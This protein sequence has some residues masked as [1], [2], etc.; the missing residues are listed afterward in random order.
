MKTIRTFHR[1][2]RT[3]RHFVV[4]NIM[5]LD[6]VCVVHRKWFSNLRTLVLKANY[7]EYRLTSHFYGFSQE[8]VARGGPIDANRYWYEFL[9]PF[10]KIKVAGIMEGPDGDLTLTETIT[11]TFP[12]LIAPF[13]WLL[14]PLFEKQKRDIL[15]AD[16]RLLERV[17]EL[18]RTGLKRFPEKA[19]KPR[20]VVFGGNGFFGRLLVQDLLEYTGANITIASRHLG[21]ASFHPYA[22]RVQF[23]VSDIN[24]DDSVRSKIEGADIAVCCAGPYQKLTLNLLQACLEKNVHYIDLSDDRNFVGRVHAAVAQQSGNRPLP[25]ICSGWSAVPALS[26]LL[27][28]FAAEGMESIDSIHIQIAPGNLSPRNVGTIASLLASVG[29]SFVLYQEGAWRAARGWSEPRTFQFP[30]P[31]GPRV[32]FLVD[33]PDHGIF[34]KI[35]GA[36]SVEFRVGSE[37]MFLNHMVS[38][39]AWLSQKRFVHDWTS[40]A[41]LFQK[42]MALFGFL[43]HEAGAAGVEVTGITK[44]VKMGKRVCVV[45]ERAGQRIPIMP[46]AIMIGAILSGKVKSSGLVPLESWLTQEQLVGECIKRE[47]RLTMEELDL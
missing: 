26:G 5:D 27:T 35:F 13:F 44:K 46:A 31:V 32:G 42:G 38:M 19:I 37:L 28:R 17:Y 8:M 23:V 22:S 41:S 1:R 4:E 47:F 15:L 34:P 25:V 14:S 33:V 40:L 3:S 43:G 18:D 29:S 11:Y 7:V 21:S 30:H 24:D 2:L 12:W 36:R 6:H 16:S 10:A 45:A 9:G 20:V 39:L